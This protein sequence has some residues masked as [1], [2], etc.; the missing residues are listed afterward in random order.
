MDFG[1]K[2]T[3]KDF[4]D[5]ERSPVIGEQDQFLS[6]IKG[7]GIDFV[8]IQ[9]ND[10]VSWEDINRLA[11]RCLE[12]ELYVSVHP[13]PS[14][15]LRAEVFTETD[16]SDS[17]TELLNNVATVKEITGRSVRLT[18]HGG[19]ANGSPCHQNLADATAHANQFVAWMVNKVETDYPD[20][21]LFFETQI[22]AGLGNEGMVRLGDTFTSLLDLAEGTDARFTWDFGHSFVSSQI[23]K[24]ALQP[25]AEFLSRV[26]HV[27]AHD[28][29][30]IEKAKFGLRDHRPIGTG[31][32]PWKEYCQLLSTAGFD[33]TIEFELGLDQ[34]ADI[35]EYE[36][37][38]A[39][40]TRDIRAIISTSDK[41]P[42]RV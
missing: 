6:R 5:K 28:V 4:F 20:I 35:E 8:E 21:L 11:G 10:S 12:H 24:Q 1:I 25:P 3:T 17:L 19:V 26:G 16:S 34:F 18:F 13:Y 23:K 29:V 2:L 7:A 42:I 15:N 38:I 27:H 33:E 41:D 14:E 36:E 9:H 40:A 32:C 22:P 37:M 30:E 39:S 31:I